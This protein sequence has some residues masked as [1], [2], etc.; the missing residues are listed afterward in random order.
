[1]TTSETRYGILH[2]YEQGNYI[3]NSE[4]EGRIDWQA[5]EEVW[6]QT[7]ALLEQT[8]DEFA[9]PV[10]GVSGG[11]DG[12]VVLHMAKQAGLD[13]AMNVRT[14][15]EY[16][17]NQ[18][19]ADS[20]P[21]RWGFEMRYMDRP[22]MDMQWILE[23]E[24]RRFFPEY[25]ERQSQLVNR[26]RGGLNAWPKD[27]DVDVMVLGRR[28][29]HNSASIQLWDDLGSHYTLDPIIEWKWEHVISYADYHDLPISPLY[30]VLT[31]SV[32]ETWY[33]PVRHSYSGQLI[34]T[35]AESFWKIRNYCLNY[36]YTMFWEYILSEFPQGETLAADWAAEND[37]RFPDIEVGYDRGCDVLDNPARVG[38]NSAGTTNYRD[39]TGLGAC[40]YGTLNKDKWTVAKDAGEIQ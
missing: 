15:E 37:I 7:I 30:R 21:R 8:N 34:E 6:N 40:I 13:T 32:G 23:D 22:K 17:S 33:K 9:Q 39:E 12:L 19:F 26:Q 28:R 4:L 18:E 5:M 31:Q 25:D 35:K 36:G 14:P 24:A 2:D 10:V 20:M 3:E 38:P 29:Q 27:K 16:P 11:I 1:M